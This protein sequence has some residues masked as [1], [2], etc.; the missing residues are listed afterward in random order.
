MKYAYN[1]ER[2]VIA[3]HGDGLG[4]DKLGTMELSIGQVFTARAKKDFVAHVEAESRQTVT[5]LVVVQGFY[6]SNNGRSAWGHMSTSGTVFKTYR[7]G[8]FG[9]WYL[10]KTERMTNAF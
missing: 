7:K 5:R 10:Y 9:G 8:G 1:K 4:A 2:T 3:Y 6:G